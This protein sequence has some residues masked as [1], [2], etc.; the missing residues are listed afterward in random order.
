MKLKR[1][2]FRGKPGPR[3]LTVCLAIVTLAGLAVACLARLQAG[4]QAGSALPGDLTQARAIRIEDDWNGLS[5]VA[6]LKAHYDLR[7]SA[8]GFNGR[9]CFSAGGNR[10]RSKETQEDISIPIDRAE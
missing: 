1:T 6:P 4:Q 9:A 5:T 2:A 7:R 3:V 10:R 8:S